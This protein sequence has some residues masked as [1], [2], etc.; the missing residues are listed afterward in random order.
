MGGNRQYTL[1]EH[2]DMCYTYILKH[3]DFEPD[4]D[5]YQD[6]AADYIERYNQGKTHGQIL[7]NLITVYRTRYKHQQQ[8]YNLPDYYIKW[9]MYDEHFMMNVYLAEELKSILNTLTIRESD[10]LVCIYY[11]GLTKDEI[12]IIYDLNRERVRQIENKAIRKLRH[13]SR[14][15]RVRDFYC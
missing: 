15:K 13:P 12:A 2:I 9:P 3:T 4:E 7:S 1:L 14:A 11:Y 5:L 8:K 10:V 6:I